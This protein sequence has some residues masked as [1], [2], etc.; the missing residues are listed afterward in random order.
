MKLRKPE[1]IDFAIALVPALAVFG[2]AYYYNVPAIVLFLSGLISFAGTAVAR[3]VVQTNQ[4]RQKED[5]SS[6]SAI[7]SESSAYSQLVE[8]AS[9]FVCIH[10]LEGRLLHVNK[11]SAE[12]LGYRPEEL[13]GSNLVD[14][15]PPVHRSEFPR[16]L[17]LAAKREF[18]SGNLVISG[19]DG[20]PMVWNYFN[21][22][23][24]DSHGEPLIIGFALDVTNQ[25]GSTEKVEQTELRLRQLTDN[26]SEVLYIVDLSISRTIYVSPAYEIVWGRPVGEMYGDSGS[27]LSYVYPKDL[28]LAQGAMETCRAGTPTDIQVRIFRPDGTTRWIRDRAF[29]IKDHNGRTYR[30]VGIS[31]D[32]TE[33]KKARDVLKAQYEV[34]SILACALNIREAG[35]PVIS[36][37]CKALDWNLGTIWTVDPKGA[38]LVFQGMWPVR[39]PAY[40]QVR[41]A[42]HNCRFLKGEGLPGK[43]WETNE[44]IWIT[45]IATDPTVVPRASAALA[46][47]LKSAFGFPLRLGNKVYGIIE[48]FSEETRQPDDELLRS[49]EL[50]G[51]QVNQ[52]LERKQAE[53]GLG[54][55]EERFR[56]IAE[57]IDEVFWMSDVGLEQAF[58]VS[59]AYEKVWA[60]DMRSVLG[61]PREFIEAVHPDDKERVIRGMELQKI[62]LTFSHE[63]RIVL[64]DDSIRWIWD[65]GFPCKDSDGKVTRY[66]GVAQDITERKN[67]ENE[68]KIREERF[69]KAFN[70][71]PIGMALVSPA[72]KFLKVNRALC[73]LTGYSK[74]ELLDLD[75]QSITHPDDLELD[76][77]NVRRL[78]SGQQRFYQMEKRYFHKNGDIVRILLSVS[79][80][81]D[82]TGEALYFVAQIQDITERK[83]MED[84]LTAA[85]DAA[86]DSARIK[87]EFLANMSHEIRT[88]M[89]GIIGMSE[90]LIG[91][92]L[93]E[94]QRDFAQTIQKSGDALLTI[95]ND[96]LDFSKLEAGKISF[97]AYEFDLVDILDETIEFFGD[98]A[99]RKELELGSVLC[100]NVP[101]AL[102]GDGGR[103][104]Q[105]LTNLISNGLKFTSNGSVILE[106]FKDLETDSHV[107]LRFDVIDT[108]IGI[109]KAAQ[110]RLFNPFTQADGSTTR[111]FGGTGLGLAISKQLVELMGGDI[112]V[113]SE[114]GKGSRFSVRA[115]FEKQAVP[116]AGDRI[117]GLLDGSQILIATDNMWLESLLSRQLSE[118][119][120]RTKVSSMGFDVMKE[121]GMAQSRGIPFTAVLLDMADEDRGFRR[122]AEIRDCESCKSVPIVP[123]LPLHRLEMLEHLKDTGLSSYLIKPLRQS[124]IVENLA[125]SSVKW[126][127]E[128]QSFKAGVA[129]QPRTDGIHTAF[130]GRILIAEDSLLN[131]KVTSRQLAKMGYLTDVVADGA[132]AVEAAGRVNYDC[133]LM[134]CHMPVMNG[135]DATAEIRRREGTARRT[136]IVA[137]TASA[138]DNDREKCITAGMDDYVAKPTKQAD[139]ATTLARWVSTVEARDR[140]G[141]STTVSKPEDL[142]DHA[143][144]GR[145]LSLFD[146][147]SDSGRQEITDLIDIFLSDT[148]QRIAD[149]DEAI[150]HGDERRLHDLAHYLKGSAQNLSARYLEELSSRLET[151]AAKSSLEGARETSELLH[152]EY[153]LVSQALSAK[154]EMLAR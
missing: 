93:T 91:T 105:L 36:A 101:T 148:S 2:F 86:L 113:D 74:H 34:A 144:I 97:E 32:I 108:G 30:I 115:K 57:A 26:I 44:A 71:A 109:D 96:V 31:E 124:R 8:S 72:G 60:R 67:S 136:P 88:P 35:L 84:D 25:I 37:I 94:E 24:R 120:A 51:N 92:N 87:S 59:P 48:F 6:N 55:S 29:P 39:E 49:I 85:R 126:I 140:S 150:D 99:A 18:T 9:A 66:A 119:G 138:I 15:V 133:I 114:P 46:G 10:D 1:P 43:V 131:Q 80:V 17:Q 116:L 122:A 127:V 147:F 13:I 41:E 40:D 45:D 14:M 102:R 130:K 76:L 75:F 58:Y 53:I 135:F 79:L 23:S 128:G 98:L 107:I 33:L 139:L 111:R 63:Y 52:F 11:A 68:L 70:Y 42:N 19:R 65:R 64:P 47:G 152:A 132:A 137:L 12:R 69:R 142:S 123:I 153:L 117:G 38:S 145:I 56:L 50:L 103:L 143:D 62:G 118:L 83:L 90:L 5:A 28:S 95:I 54:Q 134:D 81:R 7:H 141:A 16:Y 77:E 20:R 78:L 129:E 22:L 154:K 125:V 27:F 21:F 149:I 73:S 151:C 106:V 82:T 104:R 61:N 112:W 89:N 4:P 146:P 110:R 100:R 3:L 121:F